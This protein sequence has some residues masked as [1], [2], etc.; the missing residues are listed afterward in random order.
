MEARRKIEPCSRLAAF[1]TA[2]GDLLADDRKRREWLW[3]RARE[4]DDE[5]AIQDLERVDP[6]IPARLADSVRSAEALGDPR[7]R[8]KAYGRMLDERLPWP[9]DDDPPCACPSCRP[10]RAR[11]D[12]AI[13]RDSNAASASVNPRRPSP[14]RR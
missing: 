11:Q 5:A 7:E 4:K 12:A 9:S 2:M 13:I 6:R 3:L 10:E 8:R 14:S 1:M